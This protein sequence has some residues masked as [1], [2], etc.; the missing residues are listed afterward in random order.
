[1]VEYRQHEQEL[2]LKYH[3]LEAQQKRLQTL[4]VMKDSPYFARIDFCSKIVH[5]EVLFSVNVLW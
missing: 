4:S 3:T 5:M 1:A 2:L